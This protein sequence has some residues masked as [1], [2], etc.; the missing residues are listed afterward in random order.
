MNFLDHWRAIQD[1]GYF[2]NH[3]A[4]SGMREFGSD[5]GLAAIEMFRPLAATDKVV[6]IG[7]GYGRESQGIAKRCANVWGIDVTVGI[8][9]KA[10]DYLAERGVRNFTPVLASH[11]ER[12]IPTGIDVV[13]SLVVMQHLPPNFVEQYFLILSAKLKPAGAFIVQFIEDLAGEEGSQAIPSDVG[14]PSVSWTCRQLVGLADKSGLIVNEVRT[15]RVAE[16]TLW[17]W[18]YFEKPATVSPE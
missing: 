2:E 5:E 4:Y 3:P 13:F 14:E 1:R 12:N 18:I 10:V 15:I 6:V 9:R 11:Y 16:Q 8:L 17:H 7:C